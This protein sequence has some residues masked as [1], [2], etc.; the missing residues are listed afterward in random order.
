M[1][2]VLLT[3]GTSYDITAPKGKKGDTGPKGDKG[4]KGA[5]GITPVK[6]ID[7]WT[8]SDKSG[9]VDDVL[10]ALPTWTGGSY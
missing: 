3:D 1:Y 2:T 4:D 9:I 6:G 8:A 7:Y 5:D 10:A